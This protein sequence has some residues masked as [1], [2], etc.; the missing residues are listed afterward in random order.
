MTIHP[1]GI[2]VE[3]VGIEESGRGRSY[4]EHDVCG[5]V[6]QLDLV[7]RFR[8]IQVRSSMDMVFS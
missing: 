5:T 7:V 4:E 6:L 8:T 2:L 3:V 1:T